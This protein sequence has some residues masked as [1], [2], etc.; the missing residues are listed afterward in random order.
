MVVAPPED[1]GDG[2]SFTIGR[3]GYSTRRVIGST[4]VGSFS[5]NQSRINSSHRSSLAQDEKLYTKYDRRRRW[6][7]ILFAAFGVLCF[8]QLVGTFVVG[9]IICNK[10]GS[11]RIG[12]ALGICNPVIF[13]HVFFF[14]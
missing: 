7:H 1:F 3:S 4:S 8:V 6:W 5:A 13:I 14:L 10:L 11:I 9:T 2:S 12:K